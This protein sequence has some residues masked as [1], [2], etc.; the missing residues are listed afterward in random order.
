MAKNRQLKQSNQLKFDKM[1]ISVGIISLLGGFMVFRSYA[2]QKSDTSKPGTVNISS[3]NKTGIFYNMSYRNDL[4]YCFKSPQARAKIAI[5]SDG[6][7][8]ESHDISKGCFIP[9]KSYDS[10]R[11]MIT[12]VSADSQLVVSKQ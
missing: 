7:L 2:A 6:S 4:K 5:Y 1:M 11:T 12:G 8:S 3:I 9:N 10:A